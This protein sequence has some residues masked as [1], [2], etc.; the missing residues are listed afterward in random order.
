MIDFDTSF[1][2]TRYKGKEKRYQERKQMQF[3]EVERIWT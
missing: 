3:G 1:K 2:F